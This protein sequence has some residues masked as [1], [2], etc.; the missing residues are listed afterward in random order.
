MPRTRYVRSAEKVFQ[1][2]ACTSQYL[3]AQSMLKGRLFQTNYK[4]NLS[5]VLLQMFS[6]QQR[7]SS[8]A[9][10]LLSSG[11]DLQAQSCPRHEWS[12]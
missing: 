5:D 6:G 2:E 1:L 8:I 10:I 7:Q 9:H 11:P 12:C 4:P 3:S